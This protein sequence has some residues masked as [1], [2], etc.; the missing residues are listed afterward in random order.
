MTISFNPTRAWGYLLGNRVTT[1]YKP[2]RDRH[3]VSDSGQGP[4]GGRFIDAGDLEHYGAF[5][6]NGAPVLGFALAAAHSNFQ[7]LGRHGL[8]REDLD[9]QP[10]FATQ[11]VHAGNAAGLDL[12]S[13]D[14]GI[15]QGLQTELAVRD[16]ITARRDAFHPAAL[17]FAEL[18]PLGHHWHINT[19]SLSDASSDVLTYLR[20]DHQ[21]V[22]T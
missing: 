15:T 22:I 14:P 17:A 4:L 7:R 10:A 16:A 18:H 21:Y 11:K 1:R 2:A 8:V 13:R 12:S 20:N 5:L 9:E 19:D 6:H 3:L